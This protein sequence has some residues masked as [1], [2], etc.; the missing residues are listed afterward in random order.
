MKSIIDISSAFTAATADSRL[1][2]IGGS[3]RSVG[4]Q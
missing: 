4:P 2:E 3:A 1:Q